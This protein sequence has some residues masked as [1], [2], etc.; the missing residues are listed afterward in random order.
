LADLPSQ[1]RARPV[2]IRIAALGLRAP[3]VA[4]GVDIATGVMQVP[5]SIATVGWYRFG[6][7]PGS[8]GVTL[9]VG[10]VDSSTQ[11]R[12]AFFGL[13]S[14]RPGAGVAVRSSDGASHPFRIVAIR[15]YPK[16]QL[17]PR[18][19]ARTGAPVL[20]LVTCGGPFD[21]ATGHYADNVVAYGVPSSR[22]GK[23]WTP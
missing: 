5:G 4:V 7:V 2:Q 20:A 15:S 10:H 6:A 9:V 17:P 23:G 13:G 21:R 8:P 3:I 16:G 14:L 19:F 18:L 1:A 12:G 22:N 11:G